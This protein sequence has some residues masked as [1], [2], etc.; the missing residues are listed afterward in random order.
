MTTLTLSNDSFNYSSLDPTSIERAF[1]AHLQRFE[2]QDRDV[3]WESAPAV[4]ATVSGDAS[5]ASLFLDAM[6]SLL[7]SGAIRVE[8]LADGSNR[9]RTA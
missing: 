9:L 8:R 4:I 5:D 1:F 2:Q 6:E 7:D 3:S